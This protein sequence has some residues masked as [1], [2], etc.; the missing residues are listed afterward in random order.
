MAAPPPGATGFWSPGG[1]SNN[2]DDTDYMGTRAEAG[3]TILT[4]FSP[5]TVSR[6]AYGFTWTVRGL[7]QE[8]DAN[9]ASDNWV[10]GYAT[11]ARIRRACGERRQW[12]S[13]F[14]RSGYATSQHR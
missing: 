5:S 10:G 1:L 6:P 13:R 8:S 9:L 11:G 2:N 4:E 12:L 3:R 7:V 14:H